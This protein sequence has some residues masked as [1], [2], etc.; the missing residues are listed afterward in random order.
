[1]TATSN[2]KESSLISLRGV[3]FLYAH[4]KGALKWQ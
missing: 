1:M 3:G 2:N 4:K